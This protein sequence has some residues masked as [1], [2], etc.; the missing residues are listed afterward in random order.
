VG[1]VWASPGPI[2]P[3]GPL[4]RWQSCIGPL[5]NPNLSRRPSYPVATAHCGP[6]APQSPV[7]SIGPKG[8]WVVL[9][10]R[11]RSTL[12]TIRHPLNGPVPTSSL[13]SISLSEREGRGEKQSRLLEGSSL[14]EI[15]LAIVLCLGSATPLKHGTRLAASLRSLFPAQVP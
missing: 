12:G 1:F 10:H 9:P 3:H 6:N 8:A 14:R 2:E 13:L 7:G 5:R 15:D 11:S 4:G